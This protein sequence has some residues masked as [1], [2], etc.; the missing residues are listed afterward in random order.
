MRLRRI[1]LQHVRNL[2]LVTLTLTGRQQFIVGANGQGKTNLLEAVGL[3]TAL[4]SFRAAD[5]R[6][7]IAH[8][9]VEAAMGFELEHERLGATRVVVRL[10]GGSKEVTVDNERILKL[11]DFLGRFP[12]VVFSS[13][14][15]QLIRGNPTGR[16]RWLDLTLAAMDPL[17]LQTLQG[18]HRALAGR[19]ALLKRAA[20]DAE[21]AAFERPLASHGARLLEIRAEGLTHLAE[22]LHAAYL[23]IAPIGS[24][25][26]VGFRYAPDVAPLAETSLLAKFA[27]WRAR[28]AQFRSTLNGPHRDDFEFTLGERLARDVA[29][30]GQQRT[31]VLALRMAQ[32]DWFFLKSGVA[33]LILADD[34][35]GE[36]DPE[37]R[38]GFWAALQNDWQVIATG[39]RLPESDRDA[40][41]IFTVANGS[42]SEAKPPGT[43]P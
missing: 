34:V 1:T 37:R 23:R 42:F 9:Q 7:L 19:N 27:G 4:R 10:E 21:L 43:L 13:Q 25:E 2:S 18:Y 35:L 28:D 29:S 8:G 3:L 39:T 24:V 15:Q 20:S 26:R 11:G 33:P 16:R 32:A 30:E 6:L 12:T 31:L 14:D 22:R 40:W 5:A 38:A 41:E 36:L 17:Y